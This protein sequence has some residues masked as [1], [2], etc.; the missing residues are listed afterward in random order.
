MKAN[1]L[2]SKEISCKLFLKKLVSPSICCCIFKTS[3]T[4]GRESYLTTL[5]QIMI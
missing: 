5:F 2:K 3:A 1:V 4:T